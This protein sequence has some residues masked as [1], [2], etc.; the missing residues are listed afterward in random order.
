MLIR[1]K[2]GKLVEIKKMDFLTDKE[3]YQKII[4]LKNIF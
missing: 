1:T 2:T 4:F 3:F